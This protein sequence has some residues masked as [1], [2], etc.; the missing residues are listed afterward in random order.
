MAEEDYTTTMTDETGATPAATGGTTDTT[1]VLPENTTNGNATRTVETTAT[2]SYASGT[3]VV[4]VTSVS[5]AYKSTGGVNSL[6]VVVPVTSIPYNGGAITAD[7][8]NA[9]LGYTVTLDE[10]AQSF[11]TL[12]AGSDSFTLSALPNGTGA[13]LTGIVKVY[14]KAGT[15]LIGEFTVTQEFKAQEGFYVTPAVIN[16]AAAGSTTQVT[17][18]AD[19]NYWSLAPVVSWVSCTGTTYGRS[20]ASLNPDVQPP[21]Y[22]TATTVEGPKHTGRGTTTLKVTVAE[23][24]ATTARQTSIKVYNKDTA[25]TVTL[26]INQEAAA[27]TEG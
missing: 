21:A 7:I 22:D 13:A 4:A 18:S 19:S 1:V 11:L 2:T 8:L 17:I 15:T 24:E 10:D 27:T 25:Q 6:V 23:N 5:Y 12:D 9:D 3:G 20:T 26:R 16:A 14:D